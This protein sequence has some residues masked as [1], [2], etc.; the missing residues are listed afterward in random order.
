[1]TVPLTIELDDGM[2]T[3]SKIAG[4]GARVGDVLKWNGSAWVAAPDYL[5]VADRSRFAGITAAETTGNMGDFKGANQNCNSEFPGSHWAS[6]DE[7]IKLG[8]EFTWGDGTRE[9][10]QSAT[11]GYGLDAR[12]HRKVDHKRLRSPIQAVLR[13]L[14]NDSHQNRFKS[15]PAP[16]SVPVR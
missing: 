1:M 14:T 6:L 15:Q 12:D 13:S 11:N 16:L 2:V 10:Y 3:A 5:Y 9:S 4:S 8:N 7:I